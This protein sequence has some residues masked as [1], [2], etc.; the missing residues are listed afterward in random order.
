V[1]APNVSF[2][3]AD[4]FT[5]EP[6]SRFDAIFFSAWLSHVPAR[7][8]GV[9]WERLA[10]WSDRVLFVDEPVDEKVKES[11]VGE[12]RVERRLTDG[13]RFHI[14]KRF[15]DPVVL[16]RDLDRLGWDCVTRRAEGDWP[17]IRGEARLRTGTPGARPAA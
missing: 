2:A 14:V 10:R 17:W 4:V 13:T 9:F 5:W 15:I 7:R 1:T 12:E 8:F 11:Y 6:A 3:V 16:A